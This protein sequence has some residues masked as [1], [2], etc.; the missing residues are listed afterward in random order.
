[1][2]GAHIAHNTVGLKLKHSDISVQ[3]KKFDP[4]IFNMI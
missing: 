3:E 1:M 4:H 2:L